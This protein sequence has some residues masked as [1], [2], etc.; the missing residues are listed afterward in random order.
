MFYQNLRELIFK[1]LLDQFKHACK[2]YYSGVPGG[3][4]APPQILNKVLNWS[5]LEKQDRKRAT[6]NV[7][8]KRR[9]IWI[10][11]VDLDESID[12][13]LSLSIGTCLRAE[14]NTRTSEDPFQSNL[15]V[16]IQCFH[17]LPCRFQW[18]GAFGQVLLSGS[19]KRQ[20]RHFLTCFLF[21][22]IPI[23][24]FCSLLWRGFRNL[25]FWIGNYMYTVNIFWKQGTCRFVL[26]CVVCSFSVSKLLWRPLVPQNWKPLWSQLPKYVVVLGVWLTGVTG[27]TF[28]PI[29]KWRD[30]WY[31]TA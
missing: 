28:T 12:R 8:L 16:S 5:S 7:S 15:W 31:S 23:V 22:F 11:R 6:K 29:R 27:V 9:W 19:R 30:W 21:P 20:N 24:L 18:T 1:A 13:F 25:F 3:A 26:T 14:N 2:V 17:H 4:T 10:S